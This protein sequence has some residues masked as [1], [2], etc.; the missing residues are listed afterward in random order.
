MENK[1]ANVF[2]VFNGEIY[3]YKNLK[4]SLEKKD[5]T[6]KQKVIPKSF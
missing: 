1:K 2:V 3:N 4:K 6:S 5:I